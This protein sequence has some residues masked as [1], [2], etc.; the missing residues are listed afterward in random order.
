[1]NGLVVG[2]AYTPPGRFARYIRVTF[3]CRFLTA[4]KAAE[5]RAAT[6][7]ARG[8][9]QGAFGPLKNSR[10]FSDVARDGPRF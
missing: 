7:E 4:Q 3:R 6:S 8:T 5:K 2:A 10:G 9:A 1:M